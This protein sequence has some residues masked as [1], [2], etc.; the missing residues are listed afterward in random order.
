MD[1]RNKFTSLLPKCGAAKQ[2]FCVAVFLLELRTLIARPRE[3]KK[4]QSSEEQGTLAWLLI[5][6]QL[7]PEAPSDKQKDRWTRG[8]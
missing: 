4:V 6:T 2:N 5:G 3:K 7:Q 1:N 8:F